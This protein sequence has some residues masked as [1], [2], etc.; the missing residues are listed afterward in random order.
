MSGDKCFEE[1]V[2]LGKS[3][4][5]REKLG[6]TNRIKQDAV[7]GIAGATKRPLGFVEPP[8]VLEGSA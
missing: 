3:T 4:R 7:G 2:G 6:T 5:A 8:R 1:L